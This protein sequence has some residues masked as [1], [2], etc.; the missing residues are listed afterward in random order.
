MPAFASLR[1]STKNLRI[2]E[3]LTWIQS[4]CL[5]LE[6]F[7]LIQCYHMSVMGF[8]VSPPGCGRNVTD[9]CGWDA[10]EAKLRCPDDVG[11]DIWIWSTGR[12]LKP[13]F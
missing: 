3:H 6:V 12:G 11:G 13:K 5:L 2:T 10:H 4:K 8:V 1:K 7:F 9:L